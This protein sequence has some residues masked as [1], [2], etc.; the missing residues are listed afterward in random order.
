[1]R[2]VP[3]N[4]DVRQ[5]LRFQPPAHTFTPMR[6]LTS[7]LWIFVILAFGFDAV[8]QPC[9]LSAQSA[10]EA[11]HE[12]TDAM[13]CHEGM[14][15][16]PSTE[17]SEHQTHDLDTCCCA[18]MLTNVVAVEAVDLTQPLPGITL[19]ASPIPDNADSIEFEY[20]PPPPRA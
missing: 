6:A 5:G 10:S 17:P 19:W 2:A 13:P 12:M 18:A 9:E 15:M 20:E 16:T 8:A 4:E 11:A 14:I 7:F 1:M 3:Q